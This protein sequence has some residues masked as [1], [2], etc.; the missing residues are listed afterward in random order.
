MAS[1]LSRRMAVTPFSNFQMVGW[2]T[3]ASAARSLWV[4]P[5]TSDLWPYVPNKEKGAAGFIPT[6]PISVLWP[7]SAAA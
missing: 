1:A 3:P 2:L 7:L 6:A 5:L 4:R